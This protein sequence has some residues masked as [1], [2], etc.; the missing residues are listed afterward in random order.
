ML[1][2]EAE[3]RALRAQIDPHFLFNS[4]NSISALTAAIRRRRGGCACCSAISCATR[5]RSERRTASPLGGSSRWPTRFSSIEQVRFGDRAADRASH[6]RRAAA[7]LVPPLLLQPLVENAVDARHRQAV[8][9]GVIRIAIASA[10]PALTMTSRTRAIPTAQAH[11]RRRRARRTCAHR[12]H[13]MFGGQAPVTRR[14]KPT[15]LAVR[16][17]CRPMA[18]PRCSA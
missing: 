3:L 10:R 11:R 15:A 14:A 2:R 1:A 18:E 4:L 5:S 7:C 17:S 6:R 8:D 16:L 12:L 9:G 13:A